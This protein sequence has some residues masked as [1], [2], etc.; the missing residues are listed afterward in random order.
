MRSVRYKVS[1]FRGSDHGIADVAGGVAVGV[2]LLRSTPCADGRRSLDLQPDFWQLRKRDTTHP[3]MRLRPRRAAVAAPESTADRDSAGVPSPAY[4]WSGSPAGWRG[5][6]PAQ[7]R[8]RGPRCSLRLL[9]LHEVAGLGERPHLSIGQRQPPAVQVG[10]AEGGVFLPPNDER[11]RLELGN[12]QSLDTSLSCR[13]AP[14]HQPLTDRR[15]YHAQR[16]SRHDTGRSRRGACR[17]APWQRD[18]G[19]SIRPARFS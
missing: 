5:R 7:E 8:R 4:L 17:C 14:S 6:L 2:D 1:S 15:S 19:G 18:W 13:Q 10:L 11:L 9:L 12:R 3:I 16:C